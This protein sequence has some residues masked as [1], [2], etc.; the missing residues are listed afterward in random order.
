MNFFEYQERARKRT[1][2][3]VVAFLLATLAVIAAIDLIVWVVV[4][5]GSEGERVPLSDLG[6]ALAVT[7]VITLLIIGIATLHKVV[8]LRS[9]GGAVAQALGGTR[10]GD[11]GTD[12]QLRRLRNVVEEMAIA[13]GVPVPEIYVVESESAI[14][15][16]AAGWSPADAAVV[17]TRGA[18]DQLKRDELQGVIAH[19]FSH[20]LN[21]DMRLN[22]RLMG[23]LFGLLAIAIVGQKIMRGAAEADD[24]RA[25][26]AAMAIGLAVMI[27]GYVGVFFGHMIK[28]GVSRS[29]EVLADASA[30]QFTRQ[31]AP[32]ADALKKV[33]GF[34]SRL[35][36]AEAENVSHMLFAEGIRTRL[37]ATHPPIE[38]RIRLLDPAFRLEAY[39][40]QFAARTEAQA[41]GL[42]DEAAAVSALAGPGGAPSAAP[43]AVDAAGVVAQ[44]GTVS[45]DHVQFAAGLRDSIPEALKVAARQGADAPALIFALLLDGRDE[46]RGRQLQTVRRV[47]GDGVAQHT[48]ALAP[49]TAALQPLQRMP[50]ALLALSALKQRPRPELQKLRYVV[51]E[52]IHADG[53]VNAFEYAL[54]AML[55]TQLGDAAR[56]SAVKPDA[57]LQLADVAGPAAQLLTVLARVGHASA[58]EATQAFQRGASAVLP[59]RTLAYQPEKDW[60]AGLDAALR[61]LDG[62]RPPLKQQLVQA[63]VHTASHDGRVTPDEYE[64][65]RMCGA[66]L[67]CPIPPLLAPV[68]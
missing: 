21:G 66:A 62:L 53:Q 38:E 15:A 4:E 51:R 68:T 10:V 60:T 39:Q 50:L 28:A 41:E 3:L 56:P 25:V 9:G 52:L 20:V 23:L 29:R 64:L 31:K 67:H 54:G 45:F 34:G 12:F 63:M 42:V 57:K 36:Q 61:A 32:L 6:P 14:N 44:V 59:Q 46:P 1:R 19:E 24:G 47:L 22:I 16:F 40:V 5:L 7:S 2:W 58:A 17:V 49:A 35:A 26:A 55:D 43:V 65:L 37:F 33:A 48:L 8:A 13:S 30:V 27:V 18:L 11:P